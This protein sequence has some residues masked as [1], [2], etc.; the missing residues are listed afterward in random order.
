MLVIAIILLEMVRPKEQ[1]LRPGHFGVPRHELTLSL[2]LSS[3]R[4]PA[5]I[6]WCVSDEWFGRS[7]VWQ[8]RKTSTLSDLFL[9]D[10]S[11]DDPGLAAGGPD[12]RE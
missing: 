12:R 4:E 11:H 5:A 3:I 8:V 9:D 2:V 7:R 1:T 10:M 6:L